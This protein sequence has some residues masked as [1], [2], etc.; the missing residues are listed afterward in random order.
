M[1]EYREPELK[2]TVDFD[3]DKYSPGEDVSAKIKLRN[4]DG[5]KLPVSSTVD[6]TLA[7]PHFFSNIAQNNLH[8]NS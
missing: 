3:Q 1:N 5:S 8:P 6:L 4:P 2:V 7:I